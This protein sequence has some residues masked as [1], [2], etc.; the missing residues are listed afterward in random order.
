MHRLLAALALPGLLLVLAACGDSTSP[1]GF[2]VGPRVDI[3]V[4]PVGAPLLTQG[5]DGYNQILCRVDLR[6][7]TTGPGSVVWG[8]ATMRFYEGVDRSTPVDSIVFPAR[9]IAAWWGKSTLSADSA[10]YSRWELW[11][12]I[13][14]GAEIEFRY[15][16]VQSDRAGSASVTTTCGPVVSASTPGPAVTALS[17]FPSDG[18]IEAGDTLRVTYTASAQAG[19]W[20]TGVVT[21][22]ACELQRFFAEPLRSG[23]TRTVDITLPAGCELGVPIRVWALALDAGAREASGGITPALT[24]TDRTPPV[25]TPLFFPPDGGSART[26]LEGQYFAGDSLYL[27]YNTSDNNALSALVWEVAPGGWRDSLVVSGPSVGPWIKI[28][29]PPEWVGATQL[30]FYARDAMGLTSNVVASAPGA[31]TISPTIDR[32]TTVHTVTGE[33]RD[34]EIDVK[35]GLYYLLQSNQNRVAIFSPAQGAVTASL[36]MPSYPTLVEITP[37]GDSLLVAFPNLRSIGVID[38][39]DPTAGPMLLPMPVLDSTPGLS[40]VQLLAA[41][42]GKLFVPLAAA[43]IHE[44]LEVDLATGAQRLRPDAG[45]SGDLQGGTLQRSFDHRSMV[46]SIGTGDRTGLLQRYDAG[47]D[48]FGALVPS[49]GGGPLSLDGTGDRTLLGLDLYDAALA[50]QRAM[51]PLAYGIIPTALSPD[52]EWVYQLLWSYGVVRSRADDGAIADRTTNPIWPNAMRIAADGSVLVTIESSYGATSRLSVIDLHAAAAA[53]FRMATR[54]PRIEA[55][56]TPVNGAA[57]P[58]RVRAAASAATG[59]GLRLPRERGAL[60]RVAPPPRTDSA[61]RSSGKERAP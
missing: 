45:A 19:L 6:A 26:T 32:P 4:T 44:L 27:I 16:A 20:A 53:P 22:G 48:G 54:T 38:L 61:S 36:P 52:G 18:E 2:G 60:V 41:A 8:S 13:P 39:R 51:P 34:L 21:G 23:V 1:G 40:P 12:W 25:V 30:S 43:G 50:H 37:G 55:A 7:T 59:S 28:P 15:Q 9:D 57:A 14:F 46:L 56:R 49:L 29:I 5:V 17:V 42:N 11:S 35:R 31:V 3:T 33:I 24:I 47:A 58:Q 10:A